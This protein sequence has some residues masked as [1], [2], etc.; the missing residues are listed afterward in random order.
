M[1]SQP[2][3]QAQLPPT[4]GL[5]PF[6]SYA[7]LV[8]MLLPLTGKVCFY[9][10][11]GVALWIS[12]GLEEPELRMHVELLMARFNRDEGDAGADCAATDHDQPTY[13]FPIRDQQSTLTGALAIVF[14]DLPSNASYRRLD[15]VERLLSPILEV[16]AHAWR[17]ESQTAA[18]TLDVPRITDD[19]PHVID[20]IDG[21]APL[22]ALLRRTI[23]LATH[24]LQC[25]F[26]AFVVTNRPFTLS[27]RASPDESDLTMNA[28]ID[29]VRGPMLR[30]MQLRTEPLL[31][32]GTA[33]GRERVV[34]Y[35]F[36]VLP[37]RPS[38]NR[39][40]ALVMLFRHKQERDFT[41]ADVSEVMQIL[42]RVPSST[43][44]QLDPVAA[45]PQEIAA[46]RATAQQSEPQQTLPAATAQQRISESEPIKVVVPPA[47]PPRAW[48]NAPVPLL[49]T[50]DAAPTME[51]RIRDA[52]REGSFDLV[53]QRISP[54]RDERRPARFEVFVRMQEAN[55][56]RPPSSFF[57]AAEAVTL[58]PE[59]DRWVIRK[60]LATLRENAAIVRSGGWEFCIN[61]A[62]Q[63]L[64]ADRFSDFIVAEVC[65]SSIPA[66]LLVFE[67]SECDALEHQ[68]ALEF[69]GARLRDVGCRIAL[70]NCRAG[71]ATFGPLHKWPVSCVKIDGSLIR[72]V[73][74]S[75]RSESIVRAVTQLAASMGIETV[76]ERVEDANLCDKLADIGMD[77]AQGFHFGQP[78]PLADLF[79]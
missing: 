40:A 31:V 19:V 72:A 38:S 15:T 11:S 57:E 17:V 23:G 77:Y 58:M 30:L 56:M 62:A 25:A 71:L 32:N 52:L 21:P 45:T 7:Q 73:G 49:I 54:L 28:A 4:N 2:Q 44:A 3:L 48:V 41:N 22:P 76:A 18:P 75:T 1:S 24:R 63:S 53:A 59:V 10:S 9:D 16:L 67:I 43:L 60:L 78:Q 20:P 79:R 37:I 42:A 68:Y 26:G 12:D 8:R 27:H 69:L 64:I 46:P 47:P 66:G 29:A 74:T 33:P 55:R 61:I 39:L 6:A 34:P 51:D 14:R 70:D 13:V 5:V 35:K 50:P 36:L 65:K